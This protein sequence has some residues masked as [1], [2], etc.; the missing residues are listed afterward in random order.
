MKIPTV[1]VW[2]MAKVGSAAILKSLNNYSIKPWHGHWIGGVEWPEAEFVT[3]CRG[4]A[5]GIIDDT[6]GPTTI[7][8]PV[9]EPGSRA[10]SSF[11]QQLGRFGKPRKADEMYR[12]LV[13]KFDPTYPDVWFEHQLHGLLGWPALHTPFEPPYAI[14]E[15]KQYTIAIIRLEDADVYFPD[16]TNELFGEPMVMCH[17]NVRVFKLRNNP[18]KKEYLKVLGTPMPESFV[19][20]CFN[21]RYARHYYSPDEL[22]FYR[23]RLLNG[24]NES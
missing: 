12:M 10:V 13:T 17:D 7:I 8:V 18:L 23:G 9:R 16:F 1:W 6:H 11:F 15:Y 4:I 22:E 14:Y 20:R 24:T 2:Q 5:E 19:D 3:K 21:Q